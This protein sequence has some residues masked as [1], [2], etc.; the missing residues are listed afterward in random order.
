MVD[1]ERDTQTLGD[2]YEIVA[3]I[4]VA[5]AVE[6]THLSV[7]FANDLLETADADVQLRREFPDAFLRG[8]LAAFRQ[9]GLQTTA[10]RI[11]GG[12][13][14]DPEEV[15]QIQQFM[16]PYDASEIDVARESFDTFHETKSP[17]KSVRDRDE[18]EY[19]MGG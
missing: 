5:L 16:S 18:Y 8:D 4:E 17:E 10:G 19:Q 14:V 9:V 11:A 15:A 1:T 3:V 7:P 13:D 6:D 12:R 2:Q